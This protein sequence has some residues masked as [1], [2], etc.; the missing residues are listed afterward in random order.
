MG[1]AEERQTKN[2]ACT[3]LFDRVFPASEIKWD[4]IQGDAGEERMA[5]DLYKIT[6][7]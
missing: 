5:S 4:T 7:L 3:T 2:P 6:I 1:P